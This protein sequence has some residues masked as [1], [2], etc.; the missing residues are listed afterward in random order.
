MKV[1]VL[2][3]IHGNLPALEVVAENVAKWGPD[4]VVVN[5]DTVNRGPA[6]LA[7]WQFVQAQA[8]WQLL[9]GNHEEYVIGHRQGAGEQDGR[10]FAINRLS[11]W[12]YMQHHGDVAAMNQMADGL[13]LF[14]PD[15]SELRLRH[16]SMQNNRDGIWVDSSVD[17]VRDQIGTPPALF[18]TAH[19]HWPFVRRVDETLVVN[20][21]SVGTPADG[22]IRA[23]YAQI[24][25]HHGYW[26]AKIVRLT[27]DRECT[28][29]DYFTSGFLAEAGPIGWLIFYEW[30][31]ASGLVYSWMRRFFQPVMTGD[32]DLELAVTHYLSEHDLPVPLP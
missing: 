3:D 31:R 11:H 18:A 1:A 21:G 17:S 15:G 4:V 26:T 14:A 16:G 7:A 27:Y 12:T 6:S 19:I 22:D 23:S 9:K 13:S 29:Q 30:W 24:V 8:K 10:L 28:R 20:S 32:I 5:G 25:W 2:S